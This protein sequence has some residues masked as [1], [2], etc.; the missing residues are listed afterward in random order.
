MP[1]WEPGQARM[2]G[3]RNE[4][5]A[6]TS[7]RRL[8]GLDFNLPLVLNNYQYVLLRLLFEAKIRFFSEPLI[9]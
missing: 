7:S 1:Y 5:D 8:L 4:H 3:T 2:V 9:F 6:R